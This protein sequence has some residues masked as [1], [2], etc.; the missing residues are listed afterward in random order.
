MWCSGRTWP[1]RCIT[2]RFPV[3]LPDPHPPCS[4]YPEL[5]PRSN[6]CMAFLLDCRSSHR[7]SLPATQSKDYSNLMKVRRSDISLHY[8]WSQPFH[9]ADS[10]FLFPLMQIIICTILVTALAFILTCRLSPGTHPSYMIVVSLQSGK[11]RVWTGILV[12]LA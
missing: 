4:I 2:R 5:L 3:P 8:I 6:W 10:I 11:S 12:R 1:R 7:R 9:P